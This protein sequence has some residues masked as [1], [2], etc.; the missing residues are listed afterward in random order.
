MPN[1]VNSQIQE[2]ASGARART[3]S[4]ALQLHEA[5][6]LL[7]QKKGLKQPWASQWPILHNTTLF[8][9][10]CSLFVARF[11][12]PSLISHLMGKFLLPLNTFFSFYGPSF[13]F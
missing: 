5:K 9:F 3:L 7:A 1:Q 4:T 10:Y 11:L 6:K 2:R 12:F 8:S 13:E